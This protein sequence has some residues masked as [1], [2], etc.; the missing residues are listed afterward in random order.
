MKSTVIEKIEGRSDDVF[1]FE[2][3]KKKILIYPDFIRRAIINSSDAI[4]N[5]VVCQ[6]TEYEIR[7][8]LE[9]QD[10]VQKESVYLQASN[11]LK[12]MLREMDLT[13]VDVV[14]FDYQHSPM[15]KFKRI[16]NDYKKT[17]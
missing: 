1:R 2:R 11:A 16:R 13:D 6:Y 9:V 4:V 5:Y 12:I 3:N 10:T 17:I 8:S 14:E 7:L 15:N